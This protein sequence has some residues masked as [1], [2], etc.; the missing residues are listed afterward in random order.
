MYENE[1]VFQIEHDCVCCLYFKRPCK[2]FGRCV[3]DYLPIDSPD[4][5]IELFFV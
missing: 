4:E 2:A 3:F 5:D 1:T